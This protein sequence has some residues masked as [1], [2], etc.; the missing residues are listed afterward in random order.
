MILLFYSVKVEEKKV[1]F[2]LTFLAFYLISMIFESWF[3]IH[4]EHR[5]K[6]KKKQ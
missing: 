6:E 2:F 3:F 1:E 5:Q 4:Y